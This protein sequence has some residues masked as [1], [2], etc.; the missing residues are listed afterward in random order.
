MS[1]RG[2]ISQSCQIAARRGCPA[3]RVPAPRPGARRRPRRACS[4]CAPD[5][6]D[7]RRP[8]CPRTRAR[9][10]AGQPP[11]D[12]VLDVVADQ[13]APAEIR[14]LRPERQERGAGG[15]MEEAERVPARARAA[16]PRPPSRRRRDRPPARRRATAGA[17][18]LPRARGSDS[19]D[20]AGRF[21]ARGAGAA[22][23]RTRARSR[24]PAAAPSR[25]PGAGRPRAPG[26][27]ARACS[28][29]P[30]RARGAPAGDW[31]PA[32]RGPCPGTSV[33]F[34]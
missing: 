21:R 4:W 23:C 8:R 34:S 27:W 17:P 14:R 18:R 7:R 2:S 26:R 32:S 9:R 28:P 30:A 25:A 22:A 20:D 15:R 19:D 11:L 3:P 29:W 13:A 6:G 10:A 5:S 16:L 24:A 1:A 33:R 12:Q 31:R